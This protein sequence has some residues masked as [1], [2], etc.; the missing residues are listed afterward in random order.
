M[1]AT[2]ARSFPAWRSRA[3]SQPQHQAKDRVARKPRKLYIGPL[4]V[5]AF[6]VIEASLATRIAGQMTSQDPS[7]WAF[8][9][10][11]AGTDVLVAPFRDLRP[12]PAMKETGVVE[13]STL[14]A[15]EAYLVAFLA[16]IFLIQL[17]HISAWFVRRA[18]SGRRRRPALALI[19]P[20]PAVP[21]AQSLEESSPQQAA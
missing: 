20:Q 21:G 6:I 14:V 10:L 19:H 18:R 13:F 4:L 15:F 7:W 17:T 12:E 11:L 2:D 5:M 8:G 16:L 3:R 1:R 9:G